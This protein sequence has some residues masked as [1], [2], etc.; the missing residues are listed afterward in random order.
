M[1]ANFS[2]LIVDEQFI[3]FHAMWQKLRTDNQLPRREDIKIKDF[4]EF[5]GNMAI[6]ERQSRDDLRARLVGGQIAERLEKQGFNLDIMPDINLLKVIDKNARQTFEVWLN[7]LFDT[8]C[9][10]LAEYSTA[11]TTGE[12][13]AAEMLLLPMRYR[14]DDLLILV[15]SRM[16][17]VFRMGEPRKY[18]TAGIDYFQGQFVDIGF[19]L[20]D[21]GAEGIAAKPKPENL[22]LW[23]RTSDEEITSPLITPRLTR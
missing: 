20:P 21:G 16:L 12:N 9:V 8:P 6:V 5:A 13:R 11:F 18:F 4:S 19:G 1:D 3:E 23:G 14:E 10:G 15:L 22:K 7:A 17:G 2:D